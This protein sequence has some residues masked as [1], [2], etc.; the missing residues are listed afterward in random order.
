MGRRVE[1]RVIDRAAPSDAVKTFTRRYLY[2]SQDI[3]AETNGENALLARHTHSALRIDDVLA[4]HVT[5]AGVTAGMAQ[6]PGSYFYLKDHLGSVTDVVSS[7]GLHVLH[8]AYSAFGTIM[9]IQDAAANDVAASPPL[10][11]AYS[12]AGREFDAETGL[13]YNRARYYDP[14]VG[15]FL[16][17]DPNPGELDDSRTVVNSYVYCAN[18]PLNY[19]DPSG[20]LF[21]LIPIFAA[22]LG[23]VI[24][25][26]VAGAVVGAIGATGIAAVL[27]GIVVGAVVGA[28]I[29]GGSGAGLGYLEGIL[30]GQNPGQ[31][32]MEGLLA[33]AMGGGIGGAI[34]GGLVGYARGAGYNKYS[35]RYDP[36]HHNFRL[37]GKQYHF[38]L[39]IWKGGI[40]GSHKQFYLPTPKLPLIKPVQ[41]LP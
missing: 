37:L 9:G 10:R 36:P 41:I 35:F 19:V 5:A 18:N 27:A 24:G 34:G 6:A 28:I 11:T 25:T 1:K 8:Y 7:A 40:D 31:L 33:G 12:F 4:T 32:A 22:F 23:S 29:G 17:K 20:E 13:F 16:Q 15:R 38:Q 14:G 30:T 21:F 2:D 3:F 39:D 26:A